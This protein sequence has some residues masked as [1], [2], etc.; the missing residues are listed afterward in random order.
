M[1]EETQLELV[2]RARLEASQMQE[3]VKDLQFKLQTLE[4]SFAVTSKGLSQALDKNTRKRFAAIVENQEKAIAQTKASLE[5]LRVAQAETW[6]SG[7]RAAQNAAAGANTFGAAVRSN[8]GDLT[9]LRRAMYATFGLVSFSYMVGEWKHVTEAIKDEA[10]ALGGYDAGL[11]QLIADA[12]KLNEK[13]LTT[14]GQ[15]NAFQLQLIAA[16][17][18]S[19]A[20][21]LA[22][23]RLELAN[24]EHQ[25]QDLDKRAK[26]YQQLRELLTEIGQARAEALTQPNYNFGSP[27][28]LGGA[29]GLELASKHLA[30]LQQQANQLA[31]I[32][33]VDLSQGTKAFQT[34]LDK[35]QSDANA[36]ARA[37]LKFRAAVEDAEQSQGKASERAAH[38]A[39]A[40]AKQTADAWQRAQQSAYETN[41]M[42]MNGVIR[43]ENQVSASF[44][45]E[46]Q[47]NAELARQNGEIS[48]SI[49]LRGNITQGRSDQDLQV[50]SMT[51]AAQAAKNYLAILQ[52]QPGALA[53]IQKA[54]PGLTIAEM[55]QLSAIKQ[56]T[57]AWKDQDVA[58]SSGLNATFKR[59]LELQELL[60]N[61]SD[62]A[63]AKFSQMGTVAQNA[64]LDAARST[65]IF[66]STLDGELQAHVR[67]AQA[68]RDAAAQTVTSE[69]QKYAKIAEIHAAADAAYAVE[70]AAGLN[71]WG[72]AKYGA[73]AAAWAALGAGISY[74][75]R[76]A[77]AAIAGGRG[78]VAGSGSS[79]RRYNNSNGSGG[80]RDSGGSGSGNSGQQLVPGGNFP[81]APKK[82]NLTV[83]IMGENESAQWL[84]NTLN[85]SIAQ[86]GVQLTATHTTGIPSPMA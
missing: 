21:S 2:M 28:I 60:P 76:S 26:A 51:K 62:E 57:R 32:F 80:S 10:Q 74:M 49:G 24:A 1:A 69:A 31:K 39:A 23:A 72:A 48:N 78:Q 50:S 68:A 65:K 63:Q 64:M 79:A 36:A 40:I 84:A 37:V 82:G 59:L 12:G 47:K 66:T 81:A 42:I 56:I 52:L 33:G 20:R 44:Q 18:D 58:I 9:A 85:R 75:A 77:A 73:A 3:G 41:R 19:H 4:R 16:I 14:F 55:A 22:E 5:R 25:Q 67:A 34:Q 35:A 27:Q 17:K 11:R 61:V 70:D 15:L 43:M 29:P 6:Q 53:A 54:Y 8:L 13:L 30:D 71:F 83:A 38:K 7:E 46:I 45:R 86:G